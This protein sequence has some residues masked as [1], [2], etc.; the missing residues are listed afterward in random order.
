MGLLRRQQSFDPLP[1]ALSKLRGSL[2]AGPVLSEGARERILARV[3]TASST[4][5]RA[6]RPWFRVG[7]LALAAC[8]PLGLVGVGAAVFLLRGGGS[9]GAAGIVRVEKS[10]D[11]VIFT[12]A[13]GKKTHTVL[14]SSD[15]ARFDAGSARRVVGGRFEDPVAGE[16]GIVFYRVE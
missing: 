16:S 4:F 6:R 5:E 11:Q 9:E 15:P 1:E 13:N 12:I 7:R 2:E 14:R 8:L 3:L 10:G